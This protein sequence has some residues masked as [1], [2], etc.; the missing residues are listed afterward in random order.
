M[1]E[2]I[3]CL[4]LS[5]NVFT[6][7]HSRFLCFI[8]FPTH[9]GQTAFD[10]RPSRHIRS[11]LFGWT[12]HFLLSHAISS[13]WSS[14]TPLL[15]ETHYKRYLYHLLAI[16][17]FMKV[18]DW[19]ISSCTFHA[20]VIICSKNVKIHVAE[21]FARYK[22]KLRY[23]IQKWKEYDDTWLGRFYMKQPMYSFTVKTNNYL[24]S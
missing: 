9:I 6:V 13:R 22:E 21:S 4:H 5:Q 20:V 10:K 19:S 11:R 23:K 15:L 14:I 24:I 12:Y 8:I 16:N 3:D 17:K 18:S 7:T 2:I 1:V